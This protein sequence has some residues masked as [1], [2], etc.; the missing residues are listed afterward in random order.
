MNANHQPG[1]SARKM[2]PHSSHKRLLLSIAVIAAA[3]AAFGIFSRLTAHSRLTDLTA[4]EAITTVAVM[5]PITGGAAGELILPGS[6]QA[7]QDA[8]IYARTSGY[9]KTR[10]VDI[11][12]QVKAGQ[13]L[14]ELDTPEVD[15]QMQ[16]TAADLATAEA[17]ATLAQ[18]TARRWSD[19]R[20]TDAVSPQEADEKIGDAAAKVALLN[21]AK[22]NLQRL[23]EL[24]GFK[25]ITAPF[26]GIVTARNTDVGALVS[27]GGGGPELFRVADMQ[28]L[29]IYINVPQA[30]ARDIKVGT[31]ATL[32]LIER[33]DQTF[34]AKVIRTARALDPTS[35]SLRVELNLDNR[36]V[37][38][39]PGAFVRVHLP[40]PTGATQ[41]RLP[42]NTLLFRKEGPQVA[43]VDA[44]QQVQ[45]KAVTIVQDFGNEFAI[46]GGITPQDRIIINPPDSLVQGQP[47]RVAPT[48]IDAPVKPEA[49]K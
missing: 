45:L 31:E 16:Q 29:R 5:T 2:T 12:D 9:V 42:V 37:K 27:A 13:L 10:L 17:N 44:N 8:P 4:A 19:L 24:Q 3:V 11:G 36:N 47:V 33:P 40:V 38:L 6:M 41:L 48:K 34:P 35:R 21:A 26:A 20:A 23:R 46:G 49:A 14:A 18:A 7:I 32:Q 43:I 1:L 22:A 39:F 30:N 28:T 15:Q 25:R